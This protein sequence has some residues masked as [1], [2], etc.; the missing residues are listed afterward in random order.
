V[1]NL[2]QENI[3]ALIEE[4]EKLIKLFEDLKH[5]S[6]AIILYKVVEDL[7]RLLK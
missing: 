4:Y 7:E 1:G 5:D 2:S 6:E 3:K